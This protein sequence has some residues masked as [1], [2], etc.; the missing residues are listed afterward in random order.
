MNYRLIVFCAIITAGLG[1]G[2]GL[3]TARMTESKF[4]SPIYQNL[5]VKYALVG[6]GIGLLIGGSQEA[7]RQ[8]KEQNSGDEPTRLTDS[9]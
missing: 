6:A 3:G 2:L 9:Y 7:L 1:A 5:G 8:L 4:V